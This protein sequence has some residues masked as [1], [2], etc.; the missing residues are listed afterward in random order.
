VVLW[1]VPGKVPQGEVKL[2]LFF[3]FVV[4]TGGGGG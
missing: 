2:H 3:P 1:E 4:H